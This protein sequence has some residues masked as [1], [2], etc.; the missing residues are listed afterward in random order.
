MIFF[1][2]SWYKI[3]YIADKNRQ[4]RSSMPNLLLFSFLRYPMY[5]YNKIHQKI[6]SNTSEMFKYKLRKGL[7]SANIYSQISVLKVY[8]KGEYKFKEGRY[9]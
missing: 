8:P 2:K 5:T 3:S 7:H 1:T 6:L 4:R 9:D